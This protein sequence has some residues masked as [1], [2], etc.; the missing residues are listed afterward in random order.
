M[1]IFGKTESTQDIRVY[2]FTIRQILTVNDLT[3][4]FNIQF[5]CLHVSLIR[6]T[7]KYNLLP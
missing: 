2:S 5:P 1:L 3:G 6:I 7:Y 4:F